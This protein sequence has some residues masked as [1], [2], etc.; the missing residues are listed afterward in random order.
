MA[1]ETATGAEAPAAKKPKQLSSPMMTMVRYGTSTMAHDKMIAEME[2]DA[3]R[4]RAADDYEKQKV[5]Q[6]GLAAG[7]PSNIAARY[8]HK[9]TNN[10][11]IARAYVPLTYVTRSGKEVTHE[12]VG[13]IIMVQDPAFE[14]ELALILFCPNCLEKSNLPP[15]QCMLTVRQSNRRW[16]LDRRAAGELHVADDGFTYRSAGTVRD[17]ERFTCGRCSWKARVD[18]NKVWPD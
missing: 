2:E 8:S 14:D 15:G 17:G 18:G 3:R 16:E 4:R 11:E 5:K 9:F 7:D 13:D 12:G 6:H 1:D 10:E